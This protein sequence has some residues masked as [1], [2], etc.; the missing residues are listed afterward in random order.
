MNPRHA[1]FEDRD[2][3]SHL[4]FALT[5]WLA[6]Q[7]VKEFRR[8][9]IDG[10]IP[11]AIKDTHFGVDVEGKAWVGTSAREQSAYRFVASIPQSLLALKNRTYRI[12]EIELN[13][14]AKRLGITIE[15][16]SSNADQD[17]GGQ[18]AFCPETEVLPR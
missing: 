11:E 5:G 15:K 4:E 13:P 12:A 14:E 17:G 2:F 10:F 7:D 9:W 3:W 1:I 6:D 8:F 16:E 18:P